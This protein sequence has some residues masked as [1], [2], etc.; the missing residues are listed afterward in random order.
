[1]AVS[2]TLSCFVI[3][4]SAAELGDVDNNGKI[5]ASDVLYLFKVIKGEIT[6]RQ[7]KARAD[8]NGDGKITAGDAYVLRLIIKGAYV[9]DRS[10]EVYTFDLY[11]D[12][13]PFI[14]DP[15]EAKL[16][17]DKRAVYSYEQNGNS[18]ALYKSVENVDG[19]EEKTEYSLYNSRHFNYY[20]V[21]ITKSLIEF[22]GKARVTEYLIDNGISI[23]GFVDRV[24]LIEIIGGIPSVL[25]CEKNGTY[26][27]IEVEQKTSYKGYGFEY[28]L[29]TIYSL[30]DYEEYYAKYKDVDYVKLIINGEETLTKY[31][32]IYPYDEGDYKGHSIVP[33]F[34][35]MEALGY[36]IRWN[37]EHTVAKITI[38]GYEYMI[39][40]DEEFVEYP[41]D[42][43]R[44]ADSFGEEYAPTVIFMSVPGPWLTRYYADG[45]YFLSLYSFE[46]LFDFIDVSATVD[47][48]GRAIT[49]DKINEGSVSQ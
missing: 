16:T 39:G 22:A 45:E 6:N 17:T 7:A 47:V 21:C 35:L 43:Y 34:T 37:E 46:L 23:N 49:I 41:Y 31:A 15:S 40:F 5:S 14:N 25:V 38:N 12:L 32:R 44:E 24:F 11:E 1:M 19:L 20:G 10:L 18:Y 42:L 3:T 2:V 28:T 26:Y 33:F 48:D 13:I 27:F 36:E 29:E 8:L 9:A 4:S 30:Y